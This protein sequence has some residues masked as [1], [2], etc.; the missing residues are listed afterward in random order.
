MG[1]T[2]YYIIA[3][4]V[5]LNYL[6]FTKVLEPWFKNRTVTPWQISHNCILLKNYEC[7]QLWRG[8]SLWQKL[9]KMGKFRHFAIFAGRCGKMWTYHQLCDDGFI[10]WKQRQV[11]TERN[12]DI[13]FHS[14]L[15]KLKWWLQALKHPFFISHFVQLIIWWWCW[16]TEF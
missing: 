14:V 12:F 16:H 2:K 9:G 1:L 6:T 11:F 7:R 13:T 8:R 10:I 5:I 3:K 4:P 15:S